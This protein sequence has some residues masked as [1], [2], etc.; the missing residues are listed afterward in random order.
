MITTL[1]VE[2]YRSLR[3]LTIPLTALN[4][5]TGSNGSGKSS[6]YRSLRLLSEAAQNNA[7]A[8]LAREGGLESTLWAG[9]TVVRRRQ[10]RGN[11]MSIGTS[12]D[13]ATLRLG[14]SGEDF[15]YSIEFGIPGPSMVSAGEPSLFDHDPEIKCESVWAGPIYRPS[16]SLVERHNGVVTVRGEQGTWDIRPHLVHGYDSMLSELSDPEATPELFRI[17]E[18]IRSWRFYDHFR[19]DADSDPR[20][21][22]IGTRTLVLSGDGADLAAALRTIYEIGDRAALEETID[23]AFPGSSMEVV[24]I[25]GRFELLLHQPGLNRPLSASELSDGTLR[26]LLLVAALLTPRPPELL[27]LNEPESSLHPDLLVPLAALISAAARYSQ[28]IVVSHARPL[29]AAVLGAAEA[30]GTDVS[31]VE[32]VKDESGETLVDD[33]GILDGPAWYWPKR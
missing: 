14:F 28:L 1:A 3:R 11:A 9:P 24:Q 17:R 20:G 32:L 30:A 26:Y 27:V 4:I 2:N 10:A 13:A 22:R 33:Q 12:G 29:V 6:L 23:H 21:S 16:T 18:R 31:L 19:T 8:A 25:A 7:V 15:G 5:V